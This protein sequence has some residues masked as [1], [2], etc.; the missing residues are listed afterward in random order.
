MADFL[1]D[2]YT[3]PREMLVPELAPEGSLSQGLWLAAIRLRGDAADQIA[4][5]KPRII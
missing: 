5:G 1:L 4:A 2:T 3:Y